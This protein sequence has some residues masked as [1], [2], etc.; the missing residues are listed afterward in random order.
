MKK[1][2]VNIPEESQIAARYLQYYSKHNRGNLK[3]N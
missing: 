3:F 2:R 1:R